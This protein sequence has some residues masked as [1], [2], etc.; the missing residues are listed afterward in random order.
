[1]LNKLWVQAYRPTNLDGYVFQNAKTEEKIR[2]YVKNQSI[3]HLVMSGSRGTGKTTLA[4][5]LKNELGVADADFKVL[6]ASDETSIDTIRG[7][8]K[9]FI[10]VMPVGDMRIVLLDEADYL[11]KHAQS[12]LR[13]MMEEYSDTARFILTCNHPTKIIPELY[14]SRCVHLQLNEFS[15]DD[16]VVKAFYILKAE[17]IP[18]KTDEDVTLLKQ[19][20]DD[21]H[22]D[23]RKLIQSLE[24]NIIDGKLT[25][26]IEINGLDIKLVEIIAQLNGGKWME[27][28]ESIVATIEDH[29]WEDIYRLL[30]D[31][32]DQ[33]ENFEENSDVWKKAIVIIADHLRHHANVADPE[34]NFSA[35][36]IKLSRLVQ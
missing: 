1:M 2:Q 19:Y 18:I 25:D 21:C 8:V 6:N 14:D 16:M 29:E 23:L 31:N 17:G 12:A 3:P 28:R 30:Y 32:I 34:I 11:S 15:K 22:P 26:A 24:D 27:V 4:F 36:V 10:S 13:R 35:C 5:I 33:V 9:S 20:V 7:A